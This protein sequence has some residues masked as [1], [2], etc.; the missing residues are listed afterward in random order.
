M[1]TTPTQG[2]THPT[3]LSV[4]RRILVF[5]QVGSAVLHQTTARFVCSEA[6]RLADGERIGAA[7]SLLRQP[8]PDVQ[9]AVLSWVIAGEGGTCKELEKALGLTLLVRRGSS[10]SKAKGPQRTM[11]TG[12]WL[13]TEKHG[14]PSAEC[15]GAGHSP[16]CVEVATPQCRGH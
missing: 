5:L 6:V 15:V 7:C 16:G 12:S 2:G 14:A 8:N 13:L 3:R 9:L 10:P 1:R 11:Q 4:G